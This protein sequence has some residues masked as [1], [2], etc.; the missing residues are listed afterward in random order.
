MEIID[1]KQEFESNIRE[2]VASL[3]VKITDNESYLLFAG[4]LQE[5]K[6]RQKVIDDRLEPEK[7]KAYVAY[8]AWN[9]LIKE[10]KA[11]LLAREAFDK[12]EM[13]AWDTEQDRI[14]REEERRLQEEARKRE[15]EA[16]LQAAVEAEKSGDKEE[17]EAI[18]NEAPAYVPPIVLPKATP[19][20]QGIS[21]RDNWTFRITDTNKIPR[22]Y[23]IPNETAIRKVV[24]ALKDK[25]NIPG[26]EVYNERIVAAGRR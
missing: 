3:P 13:A 17:A 8:Q 15:E 25:S 21:Y 14:R 23:M 20:V 24:S 10:L 9:D 22:E 1:L 18:I 12:K 26:I 4:E 7:K 5:I 19:K 2:Y 6:R 16:R 11:P